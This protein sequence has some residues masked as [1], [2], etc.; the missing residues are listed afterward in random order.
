M[1]VAPLQSRVFAVLCGRIVADRSV[2]LFSARYDAERPGPNGRVPTWG[3]RT[4]VVVP[5]THDLHELALFHGFPSD[6]EMEAYL[7]GAGFQWGLLPDHR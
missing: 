6:V 1:R 4:R 3:W 2:G 7:A 5:G